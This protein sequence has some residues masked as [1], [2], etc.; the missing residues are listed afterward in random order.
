MILHIFMYNV[1]SDFSAATPASEGRVNSK[2]CTRY[3]Q[4]T[5]DHDLNMLLNWFKANKL[6]LNLQKTV[7]MWFGKNSN[8][9]KIKMDDITIPTVKYT[10]FLG[11]YLDDE[12]TWH[13]HINYIL[14]KIRT[15]K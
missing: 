7:M 6:S 8:S 1:T 12:L 9:I 4:Y 3:L 14:D 15:N 2:K 11:V 13:V 10:K 5:I